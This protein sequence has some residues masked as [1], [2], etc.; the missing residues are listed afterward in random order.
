MVHANLQRR[1]PHD[2]AEGRRLPV[3]R[4][5]PEHRIAWVGRLIGRIEVGEV[6]KASRL[7]LG[8]RIDPVEGR[9]EARAT[10]ALG[11]QLELIEFGESRTGI[12]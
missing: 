10:T 8:L 11:V 5:D 6:E 12:G 4:R 7:L 9:L 3:R 2:L 1:Q